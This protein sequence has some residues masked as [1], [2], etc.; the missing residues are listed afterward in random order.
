MR[1]VLPAAV[2][3]VLIAFFWVGLRLNPGEVPSPLIGKPG[4]AF[5]LPELADPAE[6]VNNA[7]M[8][9]RPVLLNVWATWCAGCRAEHQMLMALAGSG[10]VPI[11]GMNYRDERDAALRWLADL[12]DPYVAVAYD[13][14]G[15]ASLDW[16]VYG[17]PETFLLDPEGTVVYKHLGPLTPTAW[18]EEFVPRMEAMRA[19]TGG[20][21]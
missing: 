11:F 3:A 10:K 7:R 5:E 2:F 20:S 16:G 19:P 17:A 8:K 15:T 1:Y 21:R 6:I 13:P 4:P 18:R 12:G 9:G 14:E